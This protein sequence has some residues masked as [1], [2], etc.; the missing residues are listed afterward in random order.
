M[1]EHSIKTENFSFMRRS[2]AAAFQ[3]LYQFEFAERKTDIADV[4]AS[5][6]AVYLEDFSE[7]DITKIL[8]ISLISDLVNTAISHEVKILQKV[9]LFL[10]QNWRAEDLSLY[11][12]VILRLATAELMVTDTDLPVIINEYIEVTKAFETDKEAKFINKIIEQVGKS[13]RSMR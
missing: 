6:Y 1:S 2:R 11:L 8:N 5:T 7:D 12:N 10:N 9:S 3:I 4:I 13:L